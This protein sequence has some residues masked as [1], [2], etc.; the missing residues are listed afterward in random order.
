MKSKSFNK[1]CIE[2]TKKRCKYIVQEVMENNRSDINVD[3]R[4]KINV[5]IVA[6]KPD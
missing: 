1:Y 2:K 6:N 3:T 5:K 4:H